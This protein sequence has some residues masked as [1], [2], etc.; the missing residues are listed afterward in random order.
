MINNRKA[1]IFGIS[2]HK[3]KRSEKVF[4]KQ[5]KP[6]GIILFSRNIKNLEQTKKLVKDIKRIFKD[7]KFPI[8]IDVEGGKVSRLNKIIDLS[9]FSQSHFEKLYPFELV[10]ELKVSTGVQYS[11][12]QIRKKLRK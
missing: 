6:W 8:L 7:Y 2:S 3:L 4:L 1:V 10:Q 9:E 11:A 5:V 12:D